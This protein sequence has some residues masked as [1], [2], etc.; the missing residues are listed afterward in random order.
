MWIIFILWKHKKQLKFFLTEINSIDPKIQFCLEIKSKNK[1][2]LQ[3][4]ILERK[5]TEFVRQVYRK[6]MA[7][8]SIIPR[9]AQAPH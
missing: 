7:V 5:E 3:D 4:V 6:S 1:L 2:P 8:N 9:K